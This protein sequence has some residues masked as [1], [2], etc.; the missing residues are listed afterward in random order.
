M[1]NWDDWQ[2]YLGEWIG[3]GAGEPGEGNGGFRF[4]FD[5]QDQ[6]LV[7][8]NFAEYPASEEKPA[9]RHDDLMVI[10]REPERSFRATY[11]D[12]EGHVIHYTAEFSQDK[13]TL[14]FIGDIQLSAPRFRF[15]Y[16]KMG[17]DA[18]SIKFEVA[19]PGKPEEFALYIEAAAQR[20]IRL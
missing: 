11:W 17:N 15:T 13:N 20:K 7:R 6:I 9:Y 3:Q 12:N 8:K 16:K 14:T 1:T 10:Y 18:L 5:L 19:P 4:Y 2:Y